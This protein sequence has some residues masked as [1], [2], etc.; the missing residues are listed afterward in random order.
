MDKVYTSIC[1]LA[2]FLW[3]EQSSADELERS[4]INALT[5]TALYEHHLGL[6]THVRHALQ[7]WAKIAML[8]FVA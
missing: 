6:V 2:E 3:A 7:S 4:P 1:R 8:L 5:C